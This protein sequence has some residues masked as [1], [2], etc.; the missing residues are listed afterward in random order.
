MLDDSVLISGLT[1]SYDQIVKEI[2]GGFDG[3]FNNLDA[4]H[5]VRSNEIEH[6]N[7]LKVS[8]NKN[9]L[10]VLYNHPHTGLITHVEEV[11]LNP[12][13]EGINND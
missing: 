2:Q 10:T 6:G 4:S 1:S 8:V 11:R 13:L 9:A 12:N 5:Y 3:V 7:F